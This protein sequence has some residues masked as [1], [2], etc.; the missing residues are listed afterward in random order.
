MCCLADIGAARVHI[1]VSRVILL[2]GPSGSGKSYV[3]RRTGLPVLCL[4][5]FYRD[6][7]DPMLPRTAT[8][9]ADWESAQSWDGDAAVAA[10]EALGRDGRAE[11]PIY[12]FGQDHRT[13][14]RVMDL[15][16]SPLFV[17]EGI[18]A[19][20]ILAACRDRKLLAAAYTLRRPRTVTY[21][22]RLARDLN[23]ARKPPGVLLRRG[24]ALLRAEPAVLARQT[25]LGAEPASA[26]QFLA[27]IAA[28]QSASRTPV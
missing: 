28:I 16:G 12:A 25:S 6:G 10:I 17:G 8:G 21:V 19:A 27:R 1:P 18:F 23:E 3:A 22:R 13:G 2:A 7:D 5:D 20:E 9:A 14:S 4:D 26:R 15:G 24:V 11:V